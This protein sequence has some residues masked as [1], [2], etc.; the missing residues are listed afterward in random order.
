MDCPSPEAAW[1]ALLRHKASAYDAEGPCR[2]APFSLPL[3]SLPDSAGK[4]DLLDVL[5][6]SD[7]SDLERFEKRLLLSTVDLN[8]RLTQEGKA[9][10]YWAP[11][12]ETNDVL[13]VDS[14]K[15]LYQRDMISFSFSS[16]CSVGV[17]AVEKK[18]GRLRLIIDCR[19]LNQKLKRPP[20]TSL[21]SSASMSE[22]RI[23]PDQSM[24]YATHD[25]ADC[26]YQFR[27]PPVLS[28]YLGLRQ[29]RAVDLGLTTVEGMEVGG[30]TMV[31]PLLT[32]LPMGFTFALHWAQ[33]AHVNIVRRANIIGSDNMLFDF[34][35]PPSFAGEPSCAQI[36]YVDN[37]IFMSCT[38]G[39]SETARAQAEA[40]LNA[41]SL[42][43]HE[44]TH[45]S[46]EVE[47]LGLRFE[48]GQCSSTNQRR[49]KLRRA[50]E[51]VLRRDRISGEELEVLVG[52]FT[53]IF[54]LRRP[55]LSIFKSVYEYM[56]RHYKQKRRPWKSVRQELAHASALLLFTFS[57]FR[58]PWHTSVTCSDSTLN[59]YAIHCAVWPQQD[60]EL[61]GTQCDR[62]RFRFEQ[63][64]QIRE[65]ALRRW[66]FG[67]AISMVDG[68]DLDRVHVVPD[69]PDVEP[70]AIRRAEWKLL[71]ASKWSRLEPIHTKEARCPLW[72]LRRMCKQ[73]QFHGHRLLFLCDNMSTVMCLEKGRAK[74]FSLLK[75]AAGGRLTNLPATCFV[76]CGG[77]RRKVTQVTWL[78][79]VLSPKTVL[80][81]VLLRRL[82]Y[83]RLGQLITQ[84]PL[85][86]EQMI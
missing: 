18:S 66:G 73:L 64:P 63:A 9:R 6:G 30:N 83:L 14:L 59:G 84:T 55:C 49:W 24:S 13:Y 4:C 41:Y 56:H 1:L 39:V 72:A 17:F 52:H 38:R 37:G 75:I 86:S 74:D 2:M 5:D 42:P 60:V 43:V 34:A 23:G 78:L 29:V 7:K 46:H 85:F 33:Q 68:P 81:H 61:A 21:A 15:Q 12:L 79:A 80:N 44:I 69:F 31:T 27:V 58:R 67:T 22:V 25:I 54:L 57:D 82:L 11:E 40:A 32:V 20:R 45:E 70:E 36:L 28:Q 53:F 19:K 3:L 50:V 35:P 48:A 77:F 10:T 62:W 51:F 71:F 16:K 8:T 65:K 26:F 47:T 76:V